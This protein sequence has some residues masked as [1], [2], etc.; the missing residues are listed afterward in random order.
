MNNSSEHR[1]LSALVLIT[2][3]RN[4][5]ALTPKHKEAKGRKRTFFFFHIVY[6]QI[7]T[8]INY[9]GKKVSE[10]LSTPK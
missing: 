5:R 8:K 4:Q 3:K 10:S 6:G 9:L 2:I 7:G 1:I